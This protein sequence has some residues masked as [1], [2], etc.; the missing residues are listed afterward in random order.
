MTDR[1][2]TVFQNGK[3]VPLADGDRLIDA[4]GN[5][6][7]GGLKATT[8]TR[9]AT[10]G[11]IANLLT[12]APGTVDGQS[13]TVGDRILVKDQSTASQNGIYTVTTVGTGADGVWARATDFDESA[14]INYLVLCQVIEG[15]V[16]GDTLWELDAVGGITVGTTAVNFIKQSPYRHRVVLEEK[17]YLDGQNQLTAA[18]IGDFVI[19]RAGYIVGA[20]VKMDGARTAGTVTVEP[21]KNG[22]GLTPTGLDLLIDGTD[23]QKDYA[24][25]AYG[26]TNYDVAAG[27]TVGFLVT[28][29]TFTPL[30]NFGTLAIE[31]EYALG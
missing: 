28:T 24:T 29:S 27:D 19:G 12:A 3:I 8:K 1:V 31:V 30:S 17:F 13:L 9:L 11:N 6:I 20:S 21:H 7:G 23:T 26:T 10:T 25:V 5:I 16:N 15:S 22:T 14:E 4:A 18:K 2:A